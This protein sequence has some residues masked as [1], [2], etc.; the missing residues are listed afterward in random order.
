MSK[1]HITFRLSEQAMTVIDSYALQFRLDSRTDAVE[2]I[3]LAFQNMTKNQEPTPIARI[4]TFF[5]R[6]K[7]EDPSSQKLEVFMN[8][9]ESENLQTQ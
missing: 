3:L 2:G 7:P 4:K 1:T 6:R 9:Q 5:S 8:A